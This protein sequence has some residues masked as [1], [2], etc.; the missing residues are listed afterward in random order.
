MEQLAGEV[1][2]LAFFFL[3]LFFKLPILGCPSS[4]YVWWKPSVERNLVW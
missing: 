4:I 2:S 1:N 3:P